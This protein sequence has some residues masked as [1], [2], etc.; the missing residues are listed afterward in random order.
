[1]LSPHPQWV[2][3]F[4]F[5]SFS[6]FFKEV[7]WV[8]PM[9]GHLY[10]IMNVR[11][12]CVSVTLVEWNHEWILVYMCFTGSCLSFLISVFFPVLRENVC[13]L[14]FSLLSLY[15]SMHKF[16][17]CSNLK[18][19]WQMCTAFSKEFTRSV[20]FLYYFRYHTET[21]INISYGDKSK[22]SSL[23]NAVIRVFMPLMC[24][25]QFKF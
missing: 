18:N 3:L 25:K 20:S 2:Q 21:I 7:L 6:F 1:M 17:C 19:V 8:W 13:P 14:F 10:A 12:N 15:P 24:S 22:I 11:E 16:P 9:C 4:S 23:F 5:F